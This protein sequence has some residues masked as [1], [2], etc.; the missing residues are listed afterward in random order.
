LKNFTLMKE[1]KLNTFVLPFSFH[2]FANKLHIRRL[3]NEG[4]IIPI[5]ELS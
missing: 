5:D 3:S 4:V 1:E 2:Q